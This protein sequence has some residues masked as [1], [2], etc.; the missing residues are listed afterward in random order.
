MS[1]AEVARITAKLEDLCRIAEAWPSAVSNTTTV[2]VDG[3]VL[4]QTIEAYARDKRVRG[5]GYN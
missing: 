2:T 4:G 5:Y 3:R 1:A